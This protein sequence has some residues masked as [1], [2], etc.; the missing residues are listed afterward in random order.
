MA[1]TNVASNCWG[2]V[3]NP[4]ADPKAPVSELKML[5][6]GAIMTCIP[7]FAVLLITFLMSMDMDDDSVGNLIA[8]L[9]VWSLWLLAIAL[10]ICILPLVAIVEIIPAMVVSIQRNLKK[11]KN[12]AA[13][14][15]DAEDSDMWADVVRRSRWEEPLTTT[16]GKFRVRTV[17]SGQFCDQRRQLDLLCQL[18]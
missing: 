9:C 11:Q 16:S 8:G 6:V 13:R 17:C 12:K 14:N 4:P 18:P 15:D 1:G 7:A 5:A 10:F 3:N 2:L